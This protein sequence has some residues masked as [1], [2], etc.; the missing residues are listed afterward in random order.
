MHQIRS[1]QAFDADEHAHNLTNWEQCYDQTT[2]GAFSGSLHELQLPGMQVFKEH[3]SQGMRQSCCVWPDALW[4]GLPQ[5]PAPGTAPAGGRINGRC[6]E[7]DTVMV[8]PGSQEFELLTPADYGIYGIV[9]RQER[10]REAADAQGY[11]LDWGRLTRHELLHV[12]SQAHARCLHTLDRLLHTPAHGH[13]LPTL[14][15]AAADPAEQLMEAL[16]PLLD[17]A[18]DPAQVSS[19]FA[20]HQRVVAKARACLLAHPDQPLDVPELCEQLH[21]SRRTLQY[22]FEHVLGLTPMQYLRILRLNGARRSLRQQG[23]GTSV[24]D[25][26]ARW[27]FWHLSQFATDF[28]KLF[29]HTPSQTHGAVNTPTPAHMSSPFPGTLPTLH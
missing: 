17:G 15:Q 11:Q 4:F 23:P 24:Q 13:S 19:S 25:V 28:R 3:T 9:V 1:I 18:R 12:D 7:G 2:P 14:P 22:C 20:R 6:A 5:R 8:R 10:L 21:V 16:L 29:G 26:A 27:G